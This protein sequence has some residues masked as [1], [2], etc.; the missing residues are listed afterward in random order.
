MRGG[1]DGGSRASRQGLVTATGRNATGAP[2]GPVP[3]IGPR[4]EPG[5][6]SLDGPQ[7]LPPKAAPI[8][9]AGGFQPTP[10]CLFPAREPYGLLIIAARYERTYSR[11]D[12]VFSCSRECAG[13]G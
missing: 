5:G 10:R 3:R 4:A 2:T 9:G 8:T 13:A 12:L 7:G 1:A 6:D 11:E